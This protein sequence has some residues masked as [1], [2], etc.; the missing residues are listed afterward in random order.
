MHYLPKCNGP[1]ETLVE[2]GFCKEVFK[3]QWF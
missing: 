1:L 3:I 2:C